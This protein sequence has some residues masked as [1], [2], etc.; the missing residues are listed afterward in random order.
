M[1]VMMQSLRLHLAHSQGKG[2]QALCR[3]HQVLGA[4]GEE[5]LSDTC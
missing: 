4:G 2:R 5:G 3:P 1:K